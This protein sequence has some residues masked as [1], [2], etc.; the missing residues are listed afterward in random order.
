MPVNLILEI[1][2]QAIFVIK[3]SFTGDHLPGLK[4]ENILRNLK[5]RLIGIVISEL[6]PEA[7]WVIFR[8][9]SPFLKV[10]GCRPSPEFDGFHGRE[11]LTLAYW[12]RSRPFLFALLSVVY[13]ISALKCARFVRGCLFWG[14]AKEL[15]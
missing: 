11:A 5:S 6:G 14:L 13:C 4:A 12:E 1:W 15:A 9:S 8:S 3:L 7:E 10:V 2:L